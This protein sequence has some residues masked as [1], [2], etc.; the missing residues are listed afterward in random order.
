MDHQQS[1]FRKFLVAS[2]AVSTFGAIH[3]SVHAQTSLAEDLIQETLGV[4]TKAVPNLVLMMDDSGSM[5]D[6]DLP[7]PSGYNWSDLLNYSGDVSY[8]NNSGTTTALANH[9][10]RR[11]NPIYN[12]MWYNPGVTYK[13][14]NDNNKPATDN[15]PPASVGEVVGTDIVNTTR[16]DPRFRIEAGIKVEVNTSTRELFRRNGIRSGSTCLKTEERLWDVCTGGWTGGTPVYDPATEQTYYTGGTCSA[17][18]K[19]TVTLCTQYDS[20]P[21][22]IEASY[23]RFEGSGTGDFIDRTKYRFVEIDRDAPGRMYPTPIDPYTG[24][25][26][27]RTDCSSKTSCTFAEEAQ[28]FANYWTYYRYRLFAAIA[29]TSQVLATVDDNVRLGYGRLNYFAGGAEMWPGVPSSKP[30]ATLPLLDGQPNPG[31]IVR[32]VRPFTKGS[33][34]RQELFT[35]L[36][37]LNG[38]GGTPTRE[39]LDAMGKYYSRIDVQSPWANLPGSGDPVGTTQLSCRR[40]F[41]LTA[42]DGAWT[43]S[44]THPTIEV[45]YPTLATGSPAQSDSTVGPTITGTGSQTG[46]VYQYQPTSELIFGN[47]SAPSGTLTDVAG[48]Y[49]IRDLRPD[50]GNVIGPS[51]WPTATGTSYPKDYSN[52]AT[53]QAMTNFIVGYGLQSTIAA[54][55]ARKAMQDGTSINWPSIDA[56]N[57]DD[58]AKI[59]DAMRAALLS[60]GDFFSAQDP[61]ELAAALKKVFASL[62]ATQGSSST[63][64][65]SSNVIRSG[66]DLVFEASYDFD[67]WTGN[68]RAISALDLVTGATPRTVWKANFPTNY[69]DRKIFTSANNSTGANFIW[70]QLSAPQQA[71][72]G[73]EQVFNYI[74][75]DRSLEAPAGPFR[76]RSGLLGTIVGASPLYSAGTHYGFNTLPGVE[77]S[78]YS[79]YLEYKRTKRTKTVFVGSN[80]GM[81]HGFR[82]D[83][84]LEMF[85]YAPKSTLAGMR[86]TS[87]PS[88]THKY[89]VN[90][91]ISEGDAF[92][93]GKWRT[94]VLGTSGAGPKSVFLLD[95]TD[96]DNVS[97]ASVKWEINELDEQD[98]GHVLSGGI[99]TRTRTGKWVVILGNG[100]ESKKHQATVLVLDLKTG[101][102]L[103]KLATN[104]GGNAKKSDRNGMGPVTPVFD[105]QRNV[106]GGY[107]GD[108]LGNLWR[109]DLS[110]NNVADWRLTTSKGGLT[111]PVFVA[112][113]PAG[114]RQPITT[115]PRVTLHPEGGL[116]VVFGTGKAFE[117]NDLINTQ[118]QT[119]YG[120]RD[121]ANAGP[122][123]KS[124]FKQLK[125]S[126]VAGDFRAIGGLTGADALSWQKHKGWY[127]DLT[128]TGVG[129]E[130][131]IASPRLNAGMLTMASYNPDNPDPCEAGGK[132]FAYQLDLAT[133]FSRTNFAGQTSNVVGAKAPDG[134]VSG[135]INLYAPADKSTERKTSISLNDLQ[136]SVRSTRYSITSG[137][138]TDTAPGSACALAA[139]SVTNQSVSVPTVCA[140]TTP[141]RV[142]RELR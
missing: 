104:K 28:N 126:D 101:K 117:I 131:I 22:I 54:A 110:S 7:P 37:G 32:G 134:V 120:F 24:A 66:D 65:V 88:Y 92:I 124:D 68:L 122:Y 56:N 98:I 83:T 4:A 82:A 19:Q 133:S 80:A 10:M 79:A 40:S 63:L 26:V 121:R 45:I 116:Y 130:R 51:L 103:A 57:S 135:L 42:T 11:R 112:T 62:S 81:L 132:S 78:S 5:M 87:S 109:F 58:R 76:P 89:L 105:G 70:S 13:P 141:M 136:S 47:N 137:N 102:T 20:Y 52:P 12:P 38:S 114:T 128:T 73:S 86:E 59:D 41:T 64:A 119:V 115:A 91:T 9:Y 84:G 96:P 23:F 93:D 139:N 25:Q 31:H 21:D 36:F 48:H 72:L 108:K 14:W 77:G 90:G 100:Y 50:L 8:Q 60:R 44:T 18:S 34:D 129:G 49:W 16:N 95:V 99:I 35:W 127:F 43:N 69:T 67:N 107:A 75:G 74:A 3:L 1:L 6:D 29:V 39:A 113:D 94:F 97:A 123:S 118:V 53:W 106:I 142:W 46:K 17:W 85:A 138:L 33:A 61:A 30:P 55:D 125:L 71:L 140:G 111:E 2:L 15:F 27:V